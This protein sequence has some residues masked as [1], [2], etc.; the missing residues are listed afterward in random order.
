MKK[1]NTQ[2][3]RDTLPLKV[4]LQEIFWGWFLHDQAHVL[5]EARTIFISNRFCYV[6]LGIGYIVLSPIL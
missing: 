4:Q 3:T 1:T 2:K 5:N 6:K